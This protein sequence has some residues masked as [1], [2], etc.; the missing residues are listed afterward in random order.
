MVD[1]HVR[2]DLDSILAVL[3]NFNLALVVGRLNPCREIL[4]ACKIVGFSLSIARLQPIGVCMLSSCEF[5]LQGGEIKQA[6]DA[7]K[8]AEEGAEGRNASANNE[9]AHFDG[10]PI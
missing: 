7:G 2:S 10:R 1:P 6:A 5:A 8:E 3:K 4:A 9:A